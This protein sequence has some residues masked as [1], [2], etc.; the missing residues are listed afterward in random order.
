MLAIGAATWFHGDVYGPY[1]VT[2]GVFCLTVVMVGWFGAVINESQAGLYTAQTDRTFRWGMFW[3]IFSEVMFFAGFFGALF[4]ARNFS[5]PWLGGE[6][7][8]TKLGTHEFLWPNFTAQWPLIHNP[9]PQLFPNPE[10]DMPPLW[11]PLLNT[12]ILLTSSVTITVAH[13]AL[14]AKKRTILPILVA[15]TALLAMCF[16]CVQAYEYHAAYTEFKLRLDSGI[17]GTTFFMLTGF[18]GAH[19]TIG[20]IMLLTIF[21]RCLRGHFTPQHHFAFQAVEWYWHFVDVVWLFL[22]IYVYV[23]PLRHLN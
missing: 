11:L 14:L 16:L 9:N 22:F 10:H 20:T 7:A 19:V 3:F 12:F 8:V 6:G 2:L 13:H 5:V 15:A 23:L 18:H 1:L 21:I 17:Y 4:Y